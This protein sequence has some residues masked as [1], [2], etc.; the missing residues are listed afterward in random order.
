M[1]KRHVLLML[2]VLAA[3][4]V[5]SPLADTRPGVSLRVGLIVAGECLVERLE[6]GQVHRSCGR[7]SLLRN[8]YSDA[9]GSLQRRVT[10]EF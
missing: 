3:L 4:Q 2:A 1:K 7:E 9:G 10:I 6:G 5:G 8:S